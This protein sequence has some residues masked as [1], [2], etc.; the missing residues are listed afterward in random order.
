MQYH[1]ILFEHFCIVVQLRKKKYIYIYIIFVSNIAVLITCIIEC[2]LLHRI[3]YIKVFDR[4]ITHS[5]RNDCFWERIFLVLPTISFITMNLEISFHSIFNG[6]CHKKQNFW[7]NVTRYVMIFHTCTIFIACP[8]FE[9]LLHPY[10][11]NRNFRKTGAPKTNMLII[12]QF[13]ANQISVPIYGQ[14]LSMRRQT[15]VVLRAKHQL[16]IDI[17]VSYISIR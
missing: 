4:F 2:V 8:E 3:K 17:S 11:R 1:E 12:K 14:N 16:F 6:W 13:C 7:R 9:I 5:F 15:P 10:F